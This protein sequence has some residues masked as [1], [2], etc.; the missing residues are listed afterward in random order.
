VPTAEEPGPAVRYRFGPFV[1]APARRLLLQGERELPLIPRYFDL[2]L[3][4][5]ERRSEAVSRRLIFDSVWPDVVVS[6]GALS[7]AVRTLRRALGDDPREPRYIRTVSRHGY[8]FVFPHVIEEGDDPDASSTRFA[9][10]ARATVTELETPAVP[11]GRAAGA[12]AGAALAGLVGGVAGGLLLRFAGDWNVPGTVPM[13]LGLV[14]AATGAIGGLGVGGGLA[15]GEARARAARPLV[16]LAGG[17]L[18]GGAVGL[19]AHALGRWTIEGLFGR[20]VPAV[21]GAPEGLAIGAVVGLAYG[22]AARPPQGSG[23]DVSSRLWAA[24]ATGLATAAG[25]VAIS[26][27]GATLAGAS[28]NAIARSFQGSQVGL[29]PLA[30]LLGE[31]DLGPLTRAVLGAWEGLLFGAG[32]VLGFTRRR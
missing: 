30:R 4:L 6:D 5:V 10:A 24:L 9:T 12:A 18:G 28:V 29:A 21:G 7:Q 11:L 19:V 23:L 15:L 20:A 17:T 3:L 27:L 1:L 8:R 2:L 16:L 13:A 32:V 25:C 26:Q 22:L 14:G 31:P